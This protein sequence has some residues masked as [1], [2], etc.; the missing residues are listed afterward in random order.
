MRLL[1]AFASL[2][3]ALVVVEAIHGDSTF[4][5]TIFLP[6]LLSTALVMAAFFFCLFSTLELLSWPVLK[7]IDGKR[8]DR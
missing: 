2:F 3:T 7:A 6:R 5:C 4:L 8:E 1:N